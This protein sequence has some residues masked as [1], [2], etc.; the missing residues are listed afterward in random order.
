MRDC[1]CETEGSRE[2]GL[3]EDEDDPGVHD[4]GEGRIET[5]FPLPPV[6]VLLAPEVDILMEGGCDRLRATEVVHGW[7]LRACSLWGCGSCLYQ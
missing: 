3:F 4:F 6:V 1:V 7:G 2:C 5:V